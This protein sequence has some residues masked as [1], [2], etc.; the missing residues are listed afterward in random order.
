M[1]WLVNQNACENDLLE[2]LASWHLVKQRLPAVPEDVL[3]VLPSSR[4][5]ALCKTADA[6][7]GRLALKEFEAW[8][9][10]MK[11]QTEDGR[12]ILGHL[13]LPRD[14]K[15]FWACRNKDLKKRP[16]E[17]VDG[18]DGKKEE[19]S[20][21]EAKRAH[22]FEQAKKLKLLPDS[23]DMTTKIKHKVCGLKAQVI[24]HVLAKQLTDTGCSLALA[25][26]NS[27]PRETLQHTFP[28]KLTPRVVVAQRIEGKDPVVRHLLPREVLT[29]KGYDPDC[30]NHATCTDSNVFLTCNNLPY[31]S[32]VRSWVLAVLSAAGKK[33]Q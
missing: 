23:Y 2:G 1:I 19:A 17:A 32:V 26:G 14:F 5:L 15:T 10:E 3:P 9:Q 29:M 11:A 25:S 6:D 18:E 13:L 28:Q 31:K 7:V 21:E 22:M 4:C 24:A 30:V 16:H 12:V 33:D 8:V 27:W 20:N